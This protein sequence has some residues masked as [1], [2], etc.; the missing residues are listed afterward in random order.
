MKQIAFLF[1]GLFFSVLVI[2]GCSNNQ[3]EKE[4]YIKSVKKWRQER[5]Q[6]LKAEDG[7]L[8]LAGLYWLEQG[9]NT[10]G[11]AI[12]SDVKF[13]GKAPSRIGTV[14]LKEGELRFESEENV[15][16]T[17]KGK[18]VQSIEL[19]TDQQ[20]NPT[21]LRHESLKWYIIKRNDR[22]GIRL[23]D[24]QSPLLEKLDS[25][26]AY[27]VK[28]EWKIRAD[29]IPYQEKKTIEV[30]NVLGETYEE[31]IP[32]VLKFQIR[33]KEY[34]LYPVGSRESLFL[35]FSDETNAEETYGGGRFLS[36]ES[37]DEDNTTYIDFNKAYNPPCAFT[38]YATC[39]L[40]PRENILQIKIKAGEKSPN[41]EVPHH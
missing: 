38:P 1:T 15:K 5:L 25:I 24:L 19:R 36:V 28:P 22:Y 35:I 13:P 17:H 11:S 14:V 30:P 27:P 7:W 29:F 4:K 23:R 32:G 21:K 31:E 39:P 10:I 20:G 12:S 26:P 16:V 40:P 9:K 2:T 3:E 33:N 6:R 18:P 41:I 37:P 8:N 34:K